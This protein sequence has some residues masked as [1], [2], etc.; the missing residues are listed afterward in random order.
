MDA[1]EKINEILKIKSAY[2][3]KKDRDR[4]SSHI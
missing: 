1:K 4:V 2:F 3:C